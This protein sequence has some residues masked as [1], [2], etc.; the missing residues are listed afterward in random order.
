MTEAPKLTLVDRAMQ[1]VDPLVSQAADRKVLTRYI[2]SISK[3]CYAEERRRV[4]SEIGAKNIEE[5]AQVP[6]LRA[7][8]DARVSIDEEQKHG[9]FRFWQGVAM[10]GAIIGSLVGIGA[11][12]ITNSV[13]DGAFD[14]A[15]RIRAQSDMTQALVN[16]Q[17]EPQAE[18]YT[19][20]GQDVTRRP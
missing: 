4:L 15:G 7:E 8:R 5:F 11:M 16:S 12:W 19:N 18:P 10:G 14:A 13:I 1:G 17:Q 6:I 20:P 9:R 3:T 2:G